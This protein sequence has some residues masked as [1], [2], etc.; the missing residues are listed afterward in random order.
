M[1]VLIELTK[2]LPT[3]TEIEDVF[4]ALEPENIYR[5]RNTGAS[6][7][8][9][10]NPG[11]ESVKATFVTRYAEEELVLEDRNVN[12][13]VGKTK[14]AGPFVKRTFNDPLQDT[15]FTVDESGASAAVFTY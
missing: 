15:T 7:I 6:H 5:W 8:V 9:I 13:P 11:E 10:R 4:I 14:V 3:G 1:D 12:V 2:I